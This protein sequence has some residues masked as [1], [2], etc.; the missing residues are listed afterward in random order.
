MIQFALKHGVG[1][2]VIVIIIAI[3]GT[4]SLFRVPVQ[5]T[6]DLTPTS[7]SVITTWPGAT[8]QDVEKEILLEQE[9]FLKNLNDLEKMT[10]T[11]T[12]GRGEIV[13]DFRV[14]VDL[15]EVL[16]RVNNALSQVPS[17]PENVNQPRITTS[18]ASD[19]PI[20]WF[21]LRPVEGN[22]RDIDIQ[23]MQDFAEDYIKRELERSPGVSQSEVF[24]GAPRQIRVYV[25]PARLAEHNI[26]ISDLRNAVRLRN[27]DFSGGDFDEGKRRYLIRTVGRFADLGEI[28]DMIIAQR[29]GSP[30]YM[31]DV[32]TVEFS[33][34]QV[35]AQVRH[36]GET[37]LALNARRQPGTNIIEVMN[38]VKA[39]VDRM[40]ET[41]LPE[42]GLILRQVS[43]DTIYIRDSVTLVRNN[44][45][46]GAI[47]ATIVLTLFLRSAPATMIGALAI[48]ICTVAAFL[49]LTL[50]GRTINVISLA[51]V[52]FAI[53]M[54]V[55]ASIVSLENIF[56][57]RTMGK[58]PFVA[59]YDGVKEVWGAILASSTTTVFVFLPI[60]FVQEEA[61]QLFADIAIAI[62]SAIVAA[63]IVSVTVI[64]T[65]SARLMHRVGRPPRTALGRGWQRLFGL[66][67]PAIAFKAAA[68]GTVEWLLKGVFRRIGLVIFMFSSACFVA[69]VLMPPTEYLP[70]GRRNLALAFMFPPPGY[71]IQ[72]MTRIGEELEAEYV[73]YVGTDPARYRNG[74]DPVP[75]LDEFFFIN[76]T[77]FLLVIARTTED[78]DL[79]RFIPPL[80]GRLNQVPGM[81]AF[82]TRPSVFSGN[83][84]GSRGMDLD[85]SGP[86]LEPLF[87]TGQMAFGQAM[88][89]LSDGDR[90]P[91][92]RPDPPSLSLGQPMLEIRPDFER[93]E[94]LGVNTSELGYLVWALADG[95]YLDEFFLADEKIDIYLY[96][97]Q[98][99][100][101][102]TEDLDNL[103]LYTNR[104]GTVPLS[105]VARV[106]ES[107]STE[108]IRRVDSQ[109]T[110]T[111]QIQPPTT[112]AL[113][114]AVNRVQTDLVNAMFES[115]QVPPGVEMRIAGASDKLRDTREA[116]GGNFVLA[117]I[118]S[119]L[120]MVA[121]FAHWGY[122]LIIMT[123]V[124][125][126]IVG[127]V[128]GLWGLNNAGLF[129]GWLGISSIEQ[130]LDVLTMLGFIIL[131]G[132][133]INNPILIV[134]QTLSFIRNEAM[135]PMKAVLE[136]TKLR[137][138]PIMMA[139]TT[140]SFGLAPLVFN[141]GAGAELYRGLGAIVLFGLFFSAVFTLTFTPA[142]LSL[143]LQL[144]VYLRRK[145]EQLAESL[146]GSL[147]PGGSGSASASKQSGDPIAEGGRPDTA[148]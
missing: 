7:V 53:G 11:A 143:F 126:G 28:E 123:S 112:I 19:Q 41:V 87:A 14:G 23:A 39:T 88:G 105:S 131:V 132:T 56:R 59:A 118:I 92:V 85:I 73:Q 101:E 65:A 72:E 52:A 114:T 74:E 89:V 22:P 116:L 12:T 79:D 111:L 107:V 127:G 124:P 141:P 119:Y 142:L 17:Y 37:A 13:L 18:S 8:P 146:P 6:P 137:V 97:T 9:D 147:V 148:G 120:L 16:V 43:D 44:L 117:V 42:R 103:L 27:R 25:D 46:L 110:V 140:T 62:S 75:S 24:G 15:N 100:V 26:T 91:N 98:G 68:V 57:H 145:R 144:G 48:P 36:N 66:I 58:K 108:T 135:E 106:V 84:F 54:T 113:E 99:T 50:A 86:D 69:L 104:G 4:I 33:R 60:V 81:F 61:G 30:V 138:R 139:V 63:A 115:G 80:M 82:V 95:A 90:S 136:A 102:S 96:S 77:Q 51:G 5:M 34:G 109:R 125:L 21:S 128:V 83:L 76:T 93:A 78:R 2:A 121:L 129:L 67:A 3:F 70:E 20:A 29:N 31:R 10:A 133:V 134:E 45:I 71:N 122:P 64:P 1:V 47:L 38:G 40:N 49:G 55:D 32:A 130:P 35:R 94:R